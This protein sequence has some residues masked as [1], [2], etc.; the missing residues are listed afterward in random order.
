MDFYW[1]SKVIHT[2]AAVIQFMRS[3]YGDENVDENEQ[4]NFLGLE[5]DVMEL[6]KCIP[7]KDSSLYAF[8]TQLI[9]HSTTILLFRPFA[10]SEES[11]SLYVSRC[12]SSASTIT[13]IIDHQLKSQG[14]DSFYT[15]TRGNQQIIYCLSAA[16]TIQ[17]A[18]RNDSTNEI[19][20]RTC[21][22]IQML[23]PK[24]P[25][26]EIENTVQNTSHQQ[27]LQ[28]QAHYQQLQSAPL[29]PQPQQQLQQQQM[30]QQQQIQQQQIQPQKIQPQQQQQQ[31]WLDR[32]EIQI[33]SPSNTS[34]TRSSPL[35]PNQSYP[36]SPNLPTPTVRKRHSRS[37]LQ[38]TTS[39][40]GYVLQSSSTYVPDMMTHRMRPTTN[41]SPYA[42]NRLSAPA[43]GS[44]YQ[45][46][47]YYLQMQ[48]QQMQQ[49]LQ[50]HQ[51][52]SSYSQPSSPTTSQFSGSDY[53]NSNSNS[54]NNSA[55]SSFSATPRRTTSLS[56]KTGLRR[57][58]SSTGE[59]VVPSQQRAA[60]RGPYINP[61]RHTLTNSTPPDLSTSNVVTPSVIPPSP[62]NLH[63]MAV[64][65]N[66]FSAP[67]MS[68]HTQL[69][70]T[71]PITQQQQQYQQ[72]SMML[73]PSFP[74][75]PV[76]PDSPNESM[77]GLLLNPWEF[78]H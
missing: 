65:N 63:A 25:V 24:S 50:Q 16:V 69:P 43:L 5:K 9:Y 67:V 53:S 10:L 52:M 47:P 41:R 33:T 15:V 3:R 54:N 51:H 2:Q 45:Q 55:G 57:S 62:R 73:D 36:H 60:N 14:L 12:L 75:D 7:H 66:R 40:D 61:R 35:M 37:S 17:K 26:T 42:N 56:R 39:D 18:F 68:N 78:P 46:S 76:I 49:Q 29:Q 13:H 27:Q 23:L 30:Q 77:M 19:Y 48:Q 22:L 31:Q 64:R 1:L 34:S 44:L 4:E 59:F 6:G 72:Q 38:F 70:Y 11:Q 21:S 28:A 71:I 58:A 20:E 8:F 32:S 74:M